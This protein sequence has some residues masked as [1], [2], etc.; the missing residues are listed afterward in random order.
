MEHILKQSWKWACQIPRVKD[1]SWTKWCTEWQPR[2]GKR[3]TGRPSRR[4]QEDIVKEKGTA[5]SKT[6]L[7]RRQWRALTEGYVLQR[8]VNA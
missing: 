8:K 3:S 7:N 6:A 1:N 2:R 5:W 4:G